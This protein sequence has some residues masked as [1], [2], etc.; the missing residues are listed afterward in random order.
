MIPL[1]ETPEGVRNFPE[2]VSTPDIA[3][4]FLG[5]VDLSVAMGLGGDTT[6]PQVRSALLDMIGQANRAG[7]PVGALAVNPAFARE[8]LDAGLNFLAYGIDTILMY[9][10]C[11][12]VMEQVLGE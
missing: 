7:V 2:I 10:T 11:R 12:Q 6:A 8:L 4:V 1:V 5:P 3:A 9:Q